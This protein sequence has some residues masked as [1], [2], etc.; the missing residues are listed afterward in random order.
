M[1][2][3]LVSVVLAYLISLPIGIKA[4]A[5]KNSNFD[6]TSSVVLFI[7][8]AMPGFWVATLLLMSFAN[9]EALNLFPASGIQP[10]TGIPA[11]AG[12]FEAMRLRLPYLILPIVAFTYSQLAFLSRI[13]RV[14]T[15]EIIGQDYIRTARAKGLSE[16]KV[17]YKHA[18]RNA[19]LPIITVFSNVFPL[20]IG[21]SVILET[22]FTIP[23]MGEQVFHAILTKDYPVII[24]VFTL[25]G[26]LTLLGYLFADILYA[27]ADPRISYSSK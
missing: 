22:I 4:A 9:T 16:N 6:K 13:T 19:L 15:L 20:A 10:V 11:D 17:I 12:W 18:F 7:L 2:F 24:D 5:N 14:S 1:F 8:Y 3:T 27:V 23:G 21:G 25:T 26:M